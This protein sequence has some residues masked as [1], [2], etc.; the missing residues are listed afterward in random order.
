MRIG[1]PGFVRGDREGASMRRRIASGTVAVLAALM[2][3]ACHTNSN[4]NTSPSKTPA[5]Q[6]DPLGLNGAYNRVNNAI[7]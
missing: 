6:Q 7:P 4:G 1:H 2:L 5:T 3:A